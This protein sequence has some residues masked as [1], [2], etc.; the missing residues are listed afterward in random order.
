WHALPF[1]PWHQP[2]YNEAG[3]YTVHL[4]LPDDQMLACPCPTR[5]KERLEAGWVRYELE[6][7]ILRDFSLTCSAR[8]QITEAQAGKVKVICMHLPDHDKYA[9][10]LVTTAADA[11]PIY[12]RWFGPYPYPQF[13]I[14]EACFGWNGNECGGMVLIDDRMFN[15]SSI[16]R[17]YAAYLIQH[18]LCHQWWYNVVGT[19][20]YA[21]TFMDEAMAVYFSHRLADET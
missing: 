10:L 7:M 1:I 18:E 5:T 13:V 14:A 19:N 3:L 15:M 16:A 12:E 20:G 6:P 2:F 8:Y 4:T 21:E 17:N 9:K 11:I